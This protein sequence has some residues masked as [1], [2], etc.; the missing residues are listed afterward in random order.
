MI[1]ISIIIETET[2]SIIP[3]YEERADIV[4]AGYGSGISAG[5]F[6][7]GV[8]SV[9]KHDPRAFRVGL[10]EVRDFISAWCFHMVLSFPCFH[11]LSY[12]LMP[13]TLI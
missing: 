3:L 13:C 1:G 2:G 10:F 6:G 4:D 8:I 7:E 5:E 9:V 12:L 11:R